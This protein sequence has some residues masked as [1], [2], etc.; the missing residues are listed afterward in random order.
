MVEAGHQFFFACSGCGQH[1]LTL[2]GAPVWDAVALCAG[3]VFLAV[4]L[5]RLWV[6]DLARE[7]VAQGSGEGDRPTAREGNT[8]D[9]AARR[10]HAD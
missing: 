1:G 10:L 5:W 8:G 6:S 7:A 2:G 3:A 9:T 4:I